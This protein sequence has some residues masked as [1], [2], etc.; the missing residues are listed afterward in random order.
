MSRARFDQALPWGLDGSV[1]GLRVRRVLGTLW[2]VAGLGACQVGNQPDA[3]ALRSARERLRAAHELA[4]GAR[5]AS[6]REQAETALRSALQALPSSGAVIAW[7]QQDGAY[8]LGELL[9]QRG[10]VDQALVDV[11]RGLSFNDTPTLA[12]ANLLELLG[13]LHERRGEKAEAIRAYEQAMIINQ[14]LLKQ[15]L[16]E[17]PGSNS[18]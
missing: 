12:R 14:V 7:L 17:T 11:Q 18:E 2:L 6:E 10:A 13:R 3:E 8:R 5:S 16:G 1:R 9:L 15:A 4:D